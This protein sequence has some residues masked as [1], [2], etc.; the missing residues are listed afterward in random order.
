MN[1]ISNLNI[2]EK[3]KEGEGEGEKYYMQEVILDNDENVNDDNN[4]NNIRSFVSSDNFQIEKR[5]DEQKE[6]IKILTMKTY[7]NKHSQTWIEMIISICLHIFIM[8]IFEVYFYF[9]YVIIIEKKMFL[10]KIYEYT[11]QFGYF[12]SRN[13]N[14]NRNQ[15]LL[16]FFPKKD[17]SILLQELYN[18]YKRAEN[19]KE[20]LLHN[21][22]LKSY[23]LLLII[24]SI[25][26]VSLTTGIYNYGYKLKWKK[27]MSENILMFLCLGV[28]EYIFFMNVMMKYSPITD[29]EIKYIIAKELLAPFTKN[30][31]V[32]SL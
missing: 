32:V 11:D 5:S 18:E 8:A 25:L 10:E 4:Y 14:N 28:F 2:T 6:E 1:I 19:E 24:T 16:L 30:S 9:N 21:L 3:E 23:K 17:S 26:I 13:I 31:S 20:K 29:D 22:M 7:T 27:I 15:I 12:Y